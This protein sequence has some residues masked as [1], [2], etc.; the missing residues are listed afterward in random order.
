[1]ARLSNETIANIAKKMTA[2]TKEAVDQLEKDYKEIVTVIYEDQI[3]EAVKVFAEKHKG[4]IHYGNQI[5]LEGHGFRWT[6]IAS[7]RPIIEDSK[8]NANLTL[9]E[10]LADKIKK[11][12]NKW[13]SAQEAYESLLVETRQALQALG[14]H[15]RIKE[16]LPEAAEFLP[17]PMSNAL[18]VNFTSLQKKLRLQPDTKKIAAVTN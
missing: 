18:V 1:M 13:E 16:N 15:N 5:H 6:Y 9:N 11:A 17:P 2:K 8:G 7:T 4:F 12:K 14:T 10:K 3:P